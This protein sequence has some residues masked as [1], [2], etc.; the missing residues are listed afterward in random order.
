MSNFVT[1]SVFEV[2]VFE[3]FGWSLAFYIAA[4]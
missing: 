4:V 2:V 3:P 1:F